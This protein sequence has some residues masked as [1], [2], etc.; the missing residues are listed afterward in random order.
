MKKALILKYRN[1]KNK[2]ETT[3]YL[4]R[5]PADVKELDRLRKLLTGTQLIL[6]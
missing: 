4:F 1:L 3:N 5:H 6:L 2:I